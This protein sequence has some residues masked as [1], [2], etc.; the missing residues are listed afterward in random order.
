[1]PNKRKGGLVEHWGNF[2]EERPTEA[3]QVQVI[4]STTQPAIHFRLG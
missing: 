2:W 1:M 3:A 4:D